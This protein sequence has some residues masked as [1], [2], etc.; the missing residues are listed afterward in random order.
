MARIVRLCNIYGKGGHGV[1]QRFEKADTLEI[2][3]AG[4]Q[5]RTYAPVED[6]VAALIE[7]PASPQGSLT[8]LHGEDL[9]VLQVADRFPDKPRKQVTRAMHDIQDGRQICP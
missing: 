8:I 9:T 5:V 4:D 7:A 6:A 3:G 1:F 2:A